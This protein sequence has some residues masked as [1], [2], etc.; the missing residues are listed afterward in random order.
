MKIALVAGTRPE[1]VK[2]APVRDALLALPDMESCWIATGQHGALADQTHLA[3]SIV[4][5]R[6]LALDWTRSSLPSLLARLIDALASEF[7]RVQPNLV[8][9]QGDTASAFAG[10]SAAHLLQIPVAHVEAGLRS[11]DLANPFPEEGFRRMIAPITNL[12]F[13]PTRSARDN[14]RAENIRDEQIFISGNT[15]VDAVEA[16][17]GADL[18]PDILD[19]VE[20]G[21]NIV[22]VTAH[23]RENWGEGVASIC[24]AVLDLRGRFSNT[25]FI[26][27]AHTNPRVRE[28]VSALLAGE[29]RISVVEPLAYPE[30]IAVLKR[31]ILV[32][33]D[34][35]GVQE[36]APSFGVPVLVLRERTERMEAVKAGTALL[37]GT[38]R[39]RIVH[40]ASRLLADPRARLKMTKSG[41]PFGDGNAGVRIA[42]ACRDFLQSSEPRQGSGLL[43]RFGL[44]INSITM[45]E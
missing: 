27:P 33:S 19:A 4:P 14:L 16:L 31:A 35:G 23:R 20:P 37:V 42:A 15:V 3:F 39:A 12:H 44:G 38:D 5:D 40:E 18:R 7:E 28:T 24:E 1:I 29:P 22:L 13:A 11:G 17:A 41:N 30:F 8:I 26:L 25:H 43:S 21:H 45:A 6:R 2:L 9:V 36:E 34:S 10:A 32:L